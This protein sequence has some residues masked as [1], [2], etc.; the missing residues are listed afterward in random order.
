MEQH[1]VDGTKSEVGRK[2]VPGTRKRA[3]TPK[4]Q[5]RTP[6]AR[7][8]VAG[9]GELRAP[10]G[11]DREC[12][13]AWKQLRGEC[14]A[15]LDLADAAMLET[16]AVALGRFRQ[17]RAAIKEH[18]LTIKVVRTSRDGSEYDDF[19]ENPA[20]KLERD[21]AMMLHRAMVELG[22]GPSARARFSGAGVEGKQPADVLEGLGELRAIAGGKA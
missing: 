6:T 19:R 14:D 18:G 2:R 22:I 10:T 5:P 9:R 8:L 20:V 3:A 13:A 16:C 7:T 4:G 1:A 17:A 12:A 21:Y 15:V 11:L